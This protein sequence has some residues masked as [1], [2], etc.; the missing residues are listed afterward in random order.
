MTF[1]FTLCPI[2]AQGVIKLKKYMRLILVFLSVVFIS[3]VAVTKGQ[4][5]ARDY[6]GNEY[7]T[8]KIG[9]Q[10]WMAENL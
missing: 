4:E 9:T 5:L 8:V 2:K 3:L 6:D 10:I 7:K 1:V